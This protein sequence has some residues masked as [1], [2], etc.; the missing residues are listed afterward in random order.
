MDSRIPGDTLRTLRGLRARR[1]SDPAT[2][3]QEISSEICESPFIVRTARRSPP[4]PLGFPEASCEPRCAT[5]CSS[6]TADP[7]ARVRALQGDTERRPWG[8][9][10]LGGC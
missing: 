2:S 4:C 5:L 9:G 6:V 8:V 10:V 7:C 1:G 3:P